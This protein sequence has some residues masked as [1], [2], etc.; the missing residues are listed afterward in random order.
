MYY[1]NIF[2]MCDFVIIKQFF[3]QEFLFSCD[4]KMASNEIILFLCYHVK[5]SAVS[6]VYV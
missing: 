6:S 3:P 4:L 5:I 2:Y 1:V